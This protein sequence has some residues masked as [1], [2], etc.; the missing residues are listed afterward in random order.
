MTEKKQSLLSEWLKIPLLF[1]IFFFNFFVPYNL[2]GIGFWGGFLSHLGLFIAGFLT[3]IVLMFAGIV[4][5]LKELV[6][7]LFRRQR[8][9]NEALDKYSWEIYCVLHFFIFLIYLWLILL[10]FVYLNWIDPISGLAWKV[11]VIALL[12]SAFVY[13][14]E[15]NYWD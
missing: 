15:M 1:V 6:M 9:E 7:R 13:Y 2:L 14:A 5:L 4:L 10:L 11:L 3:G 8:E 12:Q